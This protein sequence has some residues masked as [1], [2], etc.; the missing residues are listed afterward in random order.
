MVEILDIMTYEIEEK[1]KEIIKLKH[2]AGGMFEPKMVKHPLYNEMRKKLVD[3]DLPAKEVKVW[4]DEYAKENNDP[5]L[6][7]SLVAFYKLKQKLKDQ[8][9]L[10]RPNIRVKIGTTKSKVVDDAQTKVMWDL[11][12][13]G[14][15]I[16]TRALEKKNIIAISNI[17]ELHATVRMIRDCL[18]EINK[19]EDN[20]GKTKQKDITI[21]LTELIQRLAEGE[22]M[23]KAAEGIVDGIRGT[24]NTVSPEV[25]QTPEQPA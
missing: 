16:I 23:D 2:N 4:L 3:E 7:F 1:P 5:S 10:D 12:N 19:M 6:T 24:E 11:V 15:E 17:A 14:T 18:S 22:T 20:L 25:V 21:V 13:A 8:V 9:A